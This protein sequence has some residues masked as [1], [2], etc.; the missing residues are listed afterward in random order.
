MG[1]QCPLCGRVAWTEEEMAV[2]A[3]GSKARQGASPVGAYREWRWEWGGG[4]YVTDVDQVEWRSVDG[5]LVPVAVFELTCVRGEKDLPPTYLQAVLRRFDRDF[6]GEAATR[7]AAL[8]GCQ[9]YI[10]VWREN[11]EDFWVFNLSRRS[12]WRSMDRDGFRAWV[13]SKGQ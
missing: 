13:T 1:D 9:A 2:T 11:L 5:E 12:G 6:Q 3:A 4:N 7:I 8:F 10:V